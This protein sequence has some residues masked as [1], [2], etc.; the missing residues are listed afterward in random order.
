M[1]DITRINIEECL[2]TL[3]EDF[4][5]SCI[6]NF[7]SVSFRGTRVL[8]VLPCHTHS[9]HKTH[10]GIRDAYLVSWGRLKAEFSKEY[11][12][13]LVVVLHVEQRVTLPHITTRGGSEHT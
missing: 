2:R 13:H 8:L 7:R 10:M 6:D 1:T 3:C 5:D 9:M 12:A 4:L 11:L